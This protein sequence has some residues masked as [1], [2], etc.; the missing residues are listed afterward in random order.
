M[1]TSPALE[2]FLSAHGAN[3]LSTDDRHSIYRPHADGARPFSIRRNGLR[4]ST[5]VQ[6]SA[7]PLATAGRDLMVQ[8]QTG[9]GKTAAFGIPLIESLEESKGIRRWF[10]A[11]LASLQSRLRRIA[12]RSIQARS[13]Y[14]RLWRCI[15]RETDR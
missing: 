9:T 10:C 5:P 11:L 13:A 6:A 14:R 3:L 7:I 2:E 12:D 4:A 1:I 8:S 15:H